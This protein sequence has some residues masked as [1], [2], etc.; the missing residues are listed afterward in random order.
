MGAPV[1]RHTLAIGSHHSVPGAQSA[2]LTAGE[3][4]VTNARA[5]SDQQYGALAALAGELDLAR[6]QPCGL[7]PW[8][9]VVESLS[10]TCAVRTR[11]SHEELL[12]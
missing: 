3:I 7:C 4:T 11:R 10:P 12:A 1:G 6:R 8:H 9:R 2:W 5:G